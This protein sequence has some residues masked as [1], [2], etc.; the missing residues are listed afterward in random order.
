M[1]IVHKDLE[2]TY[3]RIYTEELP[4]LIDSLKSMQNLPESLCDTISTIEKNIEENKA[5]IPSLLEYN[6]ATWTAMATIKAVSIFSRLNKKKQMK[7]LS[8]QRL[9]AVQDNSTHF[10]DTI[11]RMKQLLA[12]YK[13]RKPDYKNLTPE[14]RQE[15]ISLVE[16][17][18]RLSEELAAELAA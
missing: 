14:E 2:S 15:L 9:I 18:K 7:K 11:Y 1:Q 13:N 16:E 8:G 5:L 10:N 4:Q 17:M 3:E 12:K 6:I